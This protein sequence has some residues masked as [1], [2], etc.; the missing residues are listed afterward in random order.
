MKSRRERRQ[1]AR[2]SRTEFK[3]QYNGKAPQTYKE[4]YGVDYERFNNK[5]VTVAK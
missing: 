4:Y 5:F 3:P 2:E 1:E